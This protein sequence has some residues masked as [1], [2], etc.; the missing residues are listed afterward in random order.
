MKS[1]WHRRT[2]N[3][4]A[5]LGEGENGS[6]SE[7]EGGVGRSCIQPG[8]IVPGT[9]VPGWENVNLGV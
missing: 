2:W 4:S 9:E 3:Q 5:R 1:T 8:T 7:H 6:I